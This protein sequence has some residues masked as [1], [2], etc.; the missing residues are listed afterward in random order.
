[1][2]KKNSIAGIVLMTLLLIL[3]GCGGELGGSPGSD[4][5]DTGILIKS[6]SIV[7]SDEGAGDHEIDTNVHLCPPDFTEPE[8][9]LFMADATITINASPTGFDDAFPASIEQCTITYLKGDENPEAPII[10]ST[11]IYPNCTLTENEAN[12]CIVVLMDVDRK[13]KFW[14]DAVTQGIFYFETDPAH[15]VARYDCDYVNNYGKS[16]TFQV[17]YDIWLADWDNC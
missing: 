12:E 4:S 16:G 7:G 14:N 2:N 11:T 8:D 9:G 15:Y 17:E 6:V 13:E 3:S 1:M 5:G 10:E